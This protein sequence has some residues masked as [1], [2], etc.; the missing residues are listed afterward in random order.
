MRAR[1]RFKKDKFIVST[2]RFELER[3]E[4]GNKKPTLS[5][6]FKGRHISFDDICDIQIDNFFV[7]RC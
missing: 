1:I 6:L 7:G 4:I 3:M 5:K 2:K